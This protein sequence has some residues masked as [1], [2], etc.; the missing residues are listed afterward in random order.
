MDTSESNPD[1]ND[2][3]KASNELKPY[4]V[5]FHDPSMF[6]IGLGG[7]STSRKKRSDDEDEEGDDSSGKSGGGGKRPK[8]KQDL[9]IGEFLAAM[10][11]SGMELQG[12]G[13]AAVKSG[14]AAGMEELDSRETGYE[15]N[16]RGISSH[17]RDVMMR[18]WEESSYRFDDVG[19]WRTFQVQM[20]GIQQTQDMS[21]S[22]SLIK[23]NVREQ[24]FMEM[25]RP[26]ESAAGKYRADKIDTK[27]LQRDVTKPIKDAAQISQKAHEGLADVKEK[28]GNFMED[29]NQAKSEALDVVKQTAIDQGLDPMVAMDTLIPDNSPTKATAMAYVAGEAAF[30]AGTLATMGKTTFLS[31]EIGEDRKKLSANE[32]KALLEESLRRLQAN[33]PQDTRASPAATGGAAPAV[34]ADDQSANHWQ[35]FEMD[36]LAEFLAADPMQEDDFKALV[37]LEYDLEENVINGNHAEIREYYGKTGDL[38]AKAQLEIESG[39]DA[40]KKIVNEATVVE[41]VRTAARYD[42]THVKLVGDS[43]TGFSKVATDLNMDS[44]SVKTVLDHEKLNTSA[45]E[46][47]LTLAINKKMDAGMS[48]AM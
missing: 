43:L 45:L 47:Q 23:G 41:D 44:K 2:P 34:S 19:E 25:L 29:W 48:L 31:N 15:R 30:G 14:A 36:D 11:G 28:I 4:Q 20:A 32:Q 40:V 12:L 27:S 26:E 24:S 6:D 9:E 42:A 10:L 8:A 13:A 1:K 38:V 5:N 16:P 17:N 33:A 46:V 39:N 7:V 37:D 35:N 22:Q 18:G 3:P 21:F